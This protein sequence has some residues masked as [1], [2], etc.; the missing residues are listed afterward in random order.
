MELYRLSLVHDV[1]RMVSHDEISASQGCRAL[2]RIHKQASQHSLF[3]VQ[4]GPF[5]FWSR[6]RTT[7]QEWHLI[8]SFHSKPS[9]DRADET[10]TKGYS[11]FTLICAA[12]VASACA[13]RVAF[14]GSFI[15]ILM[16][17]ALG[18]LLAIVGFTA[19]E[20]NNLISNVFE[21][22]M[23]GFLSFVAV[24]LPSSSPVAVAAVVEEGLA[25]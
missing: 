5:G 2:R 17:A 6:T 18:A 23:A 14:S 25:I 19:A 15:D 8:C 11:K 1:Y 20:R 3:L 16:S 7:V 24:S 4:R 10:Q 21:I 12:T 9:R 13:A 22:G